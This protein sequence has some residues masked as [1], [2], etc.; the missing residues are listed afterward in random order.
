MRAHGARL[1]G[2]NCLGDR[3][4]PR[5][6]LNATFAPHAFPP[7]NIGF[8]SQSGALGLALL[9][10][11]TARGLGLSAFV[12]IGNKAD[13]SS[14]DLLEYWEDD[15][16]TE[17]VLL[18]LESFGNP[19]KFARIARR[20]A[21]QK[22][23]LAMKSG[24][25]T[26]RRA[27]RRLAHRRARR[28][29]GRGRR[30]VP[31]GRRDP[32]RHARGAL[33]VA[34]LLSTQ[35]LPRGRRVAVLTNAGGLGILCADACEARR[36]RAARSSPRRRGARSRALLPREAS[37]ANPVDMLG[38]A[39]AATYEAALPPL[40]ADPGVDAVIVLFVPPVVAGA[41]EVA[42]AVAPR[43][44]AGRAAGQAGAG[45]RSSAP[46]GSPRRCARRIRRSRRS[47]TRSRRRGRS[48]ARPSAPSGCGGRRAP[49]P[50]STA[51]TAPRP[52]RSSLARSTGRTTPGSTAP[53]CASC[54][55]PTASRSS[56][57]RVARRADEAVDAARELGF[58]VVVKTAAPGAHKTETR[59]RRARPRATR[60]P[61]A[62][63]SSGSAAPVLVQPMVARRRRAARR[64][65]PGPGLR[66]A[67]RVRPRRRLRRA[68]RRGAVPDRA[69]DRRRTPRSSSRPARPGTLVAGFRGAPAADAGCA[70]RSR[71]PARAPRPRTCPRS[72]SST[73]TRCSAWPTAASPSMR[74]SA[75]AAPSERR[76]EDLVAACAAGS[77]RSSRRAPDVARL[78]GDRR[79]RTEGGRHE[80]Q[81]SDDH[82]RAHRADGRA[83]KEAAALLAEHRISGLPVVDARRP[84]ARRPLRGRHPASRSSA[85]RDR[86][87]LLETLRVAVDG[88][89]P[90]A[91]GQRR[92]ARRC[93]RRR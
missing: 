79:R 28:L 21:R 36:A 55:R 32:R 6:G 53:R 80:S 62:R 3:R 37:L 91:R 10:Q 25:T 69:A 68:D 72:P 41:E 47:R 19:R 27:R 86:P 18:Y 92:S 4:P 5:V 81:G 34:A 82:R 42:E 73:S 14:N 74:A 85:H 2:P 20:V 90:K 45:R 93:R 71:P 33:D 24:R 83:L 38:S 61:S 67:R 40:L 16:S 70:R 39:T 51:S 54:S 48:A 84:R 11:A 52:R 60:R 26:R 12:S 8:S 43:R 89:R 35:P 77:R 75:F 87:S 30:A 7:G 49:C 13:V 66:A 65:R 22:P 64:R 56:P 50:S 57:E 76:D 46:T 23:I 17:V 29:G 78:A 88:L 9:E 31:P 59:R 58:P 1:I 44:R 63:P 15:P